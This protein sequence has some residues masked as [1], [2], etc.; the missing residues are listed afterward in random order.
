[1]HI[2]NHLW[3]FAA[4]ILWPSI[5]AAAEPPDTDEIRSLRTE[6]E[7]LLQTA[8]RETQRVPELEKESQRE[9]SR[10]EAL[11]GELGRARAL[12][13]EAQ[14]E[15]AREETA[16]NAA[17][18]E[19]AG[20]REKA[21]ALQGFPKRIWDLLARDPRQPREALARL[22]LQDRALLT[23]TLARLTAEPAAQA[24]AAVDDLAKQ[25]AEPLPTE[26]MRA[27]GEAARPAPDAPKKPDA[28]ALWDALAEAIDEA[29]VCAGTTMADL[30]LEPHLIGPRR[31]DLVGALGTLSERL[32]AAL[33]A[34]ETALRPAIEAT[35][36]RLRA[37]LGSDRLARAIARGAVA[38]GL[39]EAGWQA[40]R[41]AL[42]AFATERAGPSPAAPLPKSAR[43]LWRALERETSVDCRPEE[44][45]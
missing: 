12:A 5:Q 42:A 14:K 24:A 19:V 10:L 28:V 41:A 36:D 26:E 2:R 23:E 21:A 39:R 43:P 9:G 38:R 20:E 16:L 17:L 45:R 37:A 27:L 35:V 44:V 7:K 1:M 30:R 34:R 31:R 11:R 25:A 29:A 18:A 6:V 32:R 33:R 15:R 22:A 40:A 4:A 13:E 3:L 8:E